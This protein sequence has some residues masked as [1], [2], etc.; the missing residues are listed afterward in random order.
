MIA[1]KTKQREV[2][3][4]GCKVLG[5]TDGYCIQGAVERMDSSVRSVY[6]FGQV[7][8]TPPSLGYLNYEVV[9]GKIYT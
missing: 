7:T 2:D 9:R 6:S 3:P 8:L 4:K 5:V 1:A